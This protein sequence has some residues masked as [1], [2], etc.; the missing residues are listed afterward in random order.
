MPDSALPPLVITSKTRIPGVLAVVGPADVLAAAYRD[1]TPV[2]LGGTKVAG[3]VV[4]LGH[5]RTVYDDGLTTE[6]VGLDAD[7]GEHSRFPGVP[8]A[9]YYVDMTR[10]DGAPKVKATVEKARASSLAR[11]S[12][13]EERAAEY[14][15]RIEANTSYDC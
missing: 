5:T 10:L 11:A 7:R 3:E 13:V 6:T 15:R 2:T 8:C 4:Y 1:G 12:A 9:A 14:E